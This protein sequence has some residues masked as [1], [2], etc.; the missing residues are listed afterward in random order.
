MGFVQIIEFKTSRLDEGMK[1]VD[2]WDK[3]T[4]GKRT[5]QRAVLCRDRSDPNKYYNIVFFDSYE[6]AMENSNLPETQTLAQQLGALGDDEPTFHDLD[7][8][9]ERS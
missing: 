1:H 7:V 2:A 9:D 3:A 8:I 4:E 6:A 5:V